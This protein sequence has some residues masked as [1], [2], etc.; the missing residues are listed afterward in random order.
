MGRRDCGNRFDADRVDTALPDQRHV[1][2]RATHRRSHGARR[3]PSSEFEPPESAECALA[4]GR[5]ASRSGCSLCVGVVLRGTAGL[6]RFH[7]EHFRCADRDQPVCSSPRE[8]RPR[9]GLRGIPHYSPRL[10]RL[11]HMDD[12]LEHPRRAKRHTGGPWHT[13]CRF[14]ALSLAG[15]TS[16]PCRRARRSWLGA[17]FALLGSPRQREGNLKLD[18]SCISNPEIRNSRLDWQWPPVQFAISDFRI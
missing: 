13:R 3:I 16:A 14:R 10:S 18:E 7:P 4:G 5:V 15:K 1:D 17:M 11:Y 6:C 8:S 2:G 12:H 9:E